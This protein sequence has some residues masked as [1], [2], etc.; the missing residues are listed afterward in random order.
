MPL[1]SFPGDALLHVPGRELLHPLE[2][3]E[4][5]LGM[6]EYIELLL[7]GESSKIIEQLS[8]FSAD[9]ISLRLHDSSFLGRCRKAASRP[10]CTEC[11]TG[12]IIFN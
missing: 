3:I 8:L 4:L 10:I 9:I 11:I 6:A 7:H 12:G 5:G 2:G 1:I